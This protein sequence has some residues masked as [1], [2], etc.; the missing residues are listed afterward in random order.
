MIAP[1]KVK[2]TVCYACIWAAG[3]PA[4]GVVHTEVI[5]DRDDSVLTRGA[6]DRVRFLLLIL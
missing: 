3:V 5:H 1:K 4:V 2:D 6:L